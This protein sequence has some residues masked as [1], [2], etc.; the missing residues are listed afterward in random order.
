MVSSAMVPTGRDATCF[1]AFFEVFLP[2]LVGAVESLE[3]GMDAVSDAEVELGF[4]PAAGGSDCAD[5][6]STG[7][8]RGNGGRSVVPSKPLSRS[9]TVLTAAAEYFP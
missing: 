7:A 3:D 9:C 6:M 2:F 1:V 5:C 8:A 4:R